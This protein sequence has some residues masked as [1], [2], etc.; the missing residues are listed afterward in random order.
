MMNEL[1][2]MKGLIEQRFGALAFMEKLQR[3][4]RQAQ[5]S[6][7]LLDQRLLALAHPQA[8]GEPAQRH[9]DETSWAASV[10]ERNLV[11][12]DSESA[13]EDSRAACSR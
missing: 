7:R 4:P 13:L 9:G 2:S 1:R 12:G 3:Q 11:T 5:L 8:G 6:Q 10:L